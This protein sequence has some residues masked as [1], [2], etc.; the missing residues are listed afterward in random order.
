MEITKPPPAEPPF[1]CAWCDGVASIPLL[2][3]ERIS[4]GICADCLRRCREQAQRAREAASAG[5]APR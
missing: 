4:H 3:S 1:A 5:R 2:P